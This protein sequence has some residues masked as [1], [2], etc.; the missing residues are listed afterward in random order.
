[1]S[2]HKD[3]NGSWYFTVRV[4]DLNGR[5]RQVKRRNIAWKLKKDAQEA[6]RAFLN[7]QQPNPDTMTYGVLFNLFVDFKKGKIKSRSLLTYTEANE[8]H[9]LPY[10]KN[11]TITDLSKPLIRKWQESLLQSDFSNSYL[12]TI[13]SNFRRVLTW[14]YKHDYIERNPFTVEFVKKDEPK[15]EMNFYTLDEF[16]QFLSVIDS[17]EDRLVFQILYWCG[18]RKGELQALTFDDIDLSNSTINVRKSYDSRNRI[19]TTPKNQTSYR[20][21]Y[22]PL[23]IVSPLTDY[24]ARVKKIAGFDTSLFLFGIDSPISSTTLE[25]RKNYYASKASVKRIRIHDF[26]HSHVSLMINNGVSDFDIAKR[27]GHSREMVNNHYGHWFV[28]NQI[29]LAE[30]LNQLYNTSLSERKI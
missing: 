14:G 15:I 17:D 24:V 2:V 22:L 9:I 23:F 28:E 5:T 1:M 19:I 12:K 20:E 3:R 21:I 13:Q 8:K 25:R 29:N 4:T 11:V 6:E 7:S 10:F 26:R 30:K 27:L 18:L 16:N